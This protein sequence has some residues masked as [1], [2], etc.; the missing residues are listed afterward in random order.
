[1]RRDLVD[2][3]R[4]WRE[5]ERLGGVDAAGRPRRRGAAQQTSSRPSRRTDSTPE[6]RLLQL[7]RAAGL[8]E[9]VPQHRVDLSPTRWFRLDF[10]WP[11]AKVYCEFDPYK[12]HGGRDKY[13]SDTNRRLEL[14]D[15]RLVRRAG[16][17]RRARLRR[18]ARDAAAPPAPRPRRL[19]PIPGDA[20]A[21]HTP[22]G[23]RTHRVSAACR[24][25][26]RGGR[27]ARARGR[28]DG[29][30]APSTRGRTPPRASGTSRSG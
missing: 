15:A 10:A 17:R 7:L 4:V 18:S 22:W 19:D 12:W 29:R 8:P 16:H 14:A 13:M 23:R 9:P 1:M 28:S 20:S 2:L 30:G 25:G 11:E 27:G 21:T 24:R 3:P 26:G 5:W 6:L